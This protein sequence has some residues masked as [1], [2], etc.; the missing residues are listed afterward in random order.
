MGD[1]AWGIS[2]DR[3]YISLIELM[4]VKDGLTEMD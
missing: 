3:R 4:L 2:R 1:L